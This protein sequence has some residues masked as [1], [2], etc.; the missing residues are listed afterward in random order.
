MVRSFY[1]VKFFSASKR[2]KEQGSGSRSVSL[3]GLPD[4]ELDPLAR[5]TDPDPSII[6]T[7]LSLKNCKNFP[8]KS[9]Q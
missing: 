8:S 1:E 2:L 4:P 3:M 9:N 5:G 7:F 6:M